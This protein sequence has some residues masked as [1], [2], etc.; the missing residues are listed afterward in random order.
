MYPTIRIC[1]I[2]EVKG[3]KRLPSDANLV[4]TPTQ[5]PYIR[6][7]DIRNGKISVDELMYVRDEDFEKIR[8]Y[9]VNRGDVCITIVGNIG[10]VGITPPN[11]HGASLTENA[12][13]LVNLHKDFNADFIAYALLTP[14]AQSQ[15]KLSAAGAAQAKLG[16]YKVN[17]IRIAAPPRPI[18]QRIAAILSA[19]DELIDNSQRR[20]K[21]LESMARG[22]YREWFVHFRFPGH[23][24]HP[25]VA[26]ALGD[27]PGGWDVKKFGDTVELKYG[28]ALKKEDRRDGEYPVFGSS[29]IVGAHDAPLVKGPG[30]I[31]GRKGNVGSVFWCNE[32]FFVIDTAYY[33]TSPL[34]LRFL[35]YVLP[36]LNF[37]N[38][39]A[40][41]PGLSRN[42]AYTLE[43]LIP[44]AKLLEKFC[45]LA[46]VYERQ[47]AT[48][49]NKIHNLRR[50]RDL[51]LPRLLSGQISLSE[52]Q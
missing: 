37:I 45:V 13:K 34:P 46:N 19:Y 10:D 8:R 43:L 29:G 12:V 6:G 30:I 23:E 25:R 44:P 36:T 26:S 51:L 18:Q 3:G 35:Y 7:R 2:A 15:M 22:L 33:V 11:L 20:I 32:D 4:T 27:I 14:D 9:T 38:S 39:D 50:T 5:H 17:E 47:A 42:Q 21:I 1:D 41:V 31:V 40:A 28:K 52:A 49:Q 48:L 24:N 16:I